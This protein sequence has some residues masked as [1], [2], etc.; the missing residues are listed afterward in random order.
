MQQRVRARM[1][2]YEV[3]GPL[4]GAL[5]L[6]SGTLHGEDARRLGT[7]AA[8]GGQRI[9]HRRI[10]IQ[11]RSRFEQRR[12]RRV[13]TD[14]ALRVAQRF[15]QPGAHA[16]L[17]GELDIH[18]LAATVEHFACAEIVPP[19]AGGIRKREGRDQETRGALGDLRLQAR[20]ALR[21]HGAPG[22]S[23]SDHGQHRTCSQRPA[24]TLYEAL[25]AIRPGSASRAHRARGEET[26]EIL[27]QF[28][29]RGIALRRFAP[30]RLEHDRIDIGRNTA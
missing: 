21:Q 19:G 3:V 28:A 30:Q 5:G 15:E 12:A 25:R 4:R 23:D 20:L 26:V 22:E 14:A 10:Q 9:V 2:L 16:R 18:A 17:P 11:L 13:F 1:T 8:C 27:R 24:I 6:F 7:Q 29:H